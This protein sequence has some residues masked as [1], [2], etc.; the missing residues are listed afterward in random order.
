VRAADEI[1]P[2]IDLGMLLS[3]R[4]TGNGENHWRK[5]TPDSQF[6]VLFRREDVD[7]VGVA[8]SE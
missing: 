6:P 7:V 2:L 4:A 1:I 3:A 5:N 8:L